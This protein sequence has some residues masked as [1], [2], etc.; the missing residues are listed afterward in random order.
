MTKSVKTKLYTF[1]EMKDVVAQC[2]AEMTADF[3]DSCED[4]EVG[5]KEV[6]LLTT[7]GAKIMTQMDKK[8]EKGEL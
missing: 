4:G 7:I 6:I 2:A 8:H 5:L 3:I 1:E